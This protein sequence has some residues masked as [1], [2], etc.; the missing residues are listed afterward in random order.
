VLTIAFA[1]V[2]IICAV[3]W[4]LS[5]IRALTL[6]CF[7]DEKN[8]TLPTEQELKACSRKATERALSWLASAGRSK[9]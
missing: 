2:A 7:L 6:I 1:I 4:F 9:R 8:Y 5:W 3:G